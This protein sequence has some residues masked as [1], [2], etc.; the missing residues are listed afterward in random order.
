MPVNIVFGEPHAYA[1]TVAFDVCV[2]EDVIGMTTNAGTP[3]CRF[4]L[5]VTDDW[6]IDEYMLDDTFDFEAATVADALWDSY[7]DPADFPPNAAD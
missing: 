1:G 2:D 7:C 3:G 6:A 4:R 5:H